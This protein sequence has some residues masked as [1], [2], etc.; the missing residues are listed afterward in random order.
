[1]YDT[2]EAIKKLT[3][4]ADDVGLCDDVLDDIVHDIASKI[5]SNINNGGVAKQI[6]F[7]VNQMGSSGEDEV[8]RLF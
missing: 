6:E 2:D 8:R 4:E 7:I 5:A 3:S 1:M